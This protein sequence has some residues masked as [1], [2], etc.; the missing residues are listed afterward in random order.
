[1]PVRP[2]PFTQVCSQCNWSKTFA[3]ASDALIAG[4]DIATQCPRCGSKELKFREPSVLA[5]L[6]SRLKGFVASR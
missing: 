2:K 1:M 4:H 5:L 6:S 3:P